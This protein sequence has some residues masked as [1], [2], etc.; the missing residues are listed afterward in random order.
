MRLM[1]TY[2]L[3]AALLGALITIACGATQTGASDAN[4]IQ[5][6]SRSAP[7]SSNFTARCASCHGERGE[8]KAYAPSIIG[9]GSLPM[10]PRDASTSPTTTDPVQLQM[11]A[12]TRPPGAPSRG[13][14]RTAKDLHDYLSQHHP[15]EG[16]R[17]LTPADLWGVVTFMLV[18]HG[19]QVPEAGIT[20]DNAASV[21]I[22]N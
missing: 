2:S 11:Q 18:A 20:P 9:A 4:L 8:G 5:A 19:S 12:Q 14:L 17:S 7:G 3:A 16:T 21:A 13:P 1:S 6:R 22:T 10:Y 15:D